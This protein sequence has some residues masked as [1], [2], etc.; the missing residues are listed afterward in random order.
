MNKRPLSIYGILLLL[1]LGFGV[2]STASAALIDVGTQQTTFTGFTRGFWFVAPTDFT[3]TGLGVPT[4]A[5]S[6]NFDVAVLR[7]AAIPPEFSAETSVFDTLFIS[8][9]N[10]GSSLLST[11]INISIGDIIGIF[12]SRG[13]NSTNSY[14]TATY[15]S[16]ILGLPVTL[17]RLLMQD[18][19]RA[20]DPAVVGVSSESGDRIGRVLV[21][22]NSQSQSVPEPASITLLVLGLAGM[23]LSRGKG[24]KLG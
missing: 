24:F 20:T 12:G 6:E 19:L 7:F 22:I 3:I 13:A 8:R 14:G 11:N 15:S 4:D 1:T 17:T 9:D 18:D 23:R 5:S 10:S 16:S 21:D 2:S